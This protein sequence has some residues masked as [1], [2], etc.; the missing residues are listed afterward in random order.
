MKVAV[1]GSGSFGTAMACVVARNGHDVVV[2]TRRED[3]ARGVNERHRNPSHLSERELPLNVRATTDPRE[4]IEGAKAIVH[5]I[6][7]QSTEGFLRD[8]ETL[9]KASGAIFVSTSKGLREDTLE[10]MH[11]LLARVLGEKHPCAFFGGPTFA[12]QLVDGTP[13]GGVMAAK[14]MATAE[15]AAALFSGPTMR[16]YPST[17][18]V[19]VEIGGALKNVIAIL[20]GGLEGM[21]SLIHI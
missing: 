6:P 9:V 1:F 21:L 17:D 8:V 20:A 7:M 11:D 19:G 13:S 12:K 5:A 15:R 2:L 4:A 14:T 3:V 10:L 16:V 18:V